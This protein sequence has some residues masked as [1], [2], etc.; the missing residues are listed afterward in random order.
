MLLNIVR[1]QYEAIIGERDVVFRKQ[2]YFREIWTKAKVLTS[3]GER[4]KWKYAPPR[5]LFPPPLWK[6]PNFR[7]VNAIS[8]VVAFGLLLLD[9]LVDVVIVVVFSCMSSL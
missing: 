8:K 3:F 1:V 2:Q 5:W 9:M 6:N 7:C 4:M